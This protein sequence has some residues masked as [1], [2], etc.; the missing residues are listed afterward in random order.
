MLRRWLG[1]VPRWAQNDQMALRQEI[2]RYMPRLSA[3]RRWV[4]FIQLVLAISVLIIAG[5]LIATG[6]LRE[7]GGDTLMQRV[8]NTLYFPILLVQG[9]VLVMAFLEPTATLERTTLDETLKTTPSGIGLW[10]RAKWLG[11]YLRVYRLLALVILARIVLLVMLLLEVTTMRGSYL[12]LVMQ[13]QV[14]PSVPQLLGLMIMALNIMGAFLLPLT[15]VGLDVALGMWVGNQ[16]KER[17]LALVGQASL[18]LLRL[19]IMLGALWLMARVLN[20]ELL[21]GDSGAGVV[22]I[23]Y[24]IWGDMGLSLLNLTLSGEIWGRVPYSVLVS[25]VLVAIIFLQVGLTEWLLR[26]TTTHL[27]KAD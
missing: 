16:A 12:D 4:L 25:V 19:F 5:Y 13:L 18:L 15:S 21:I 26:N 2:M 9:A 7:S 3:R 22:Y 8:W 6:L 11:G 17:T 20:N 27:E 1:E 23:G 24:T 10:V 14:E